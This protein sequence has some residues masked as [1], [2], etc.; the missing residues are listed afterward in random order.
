VGGVG[1]VESDGVESYGN[2]RNVHLQY[3]E[4]SQ[5]MVICRDMKLGAE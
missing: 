5:R 2:E 1:H 4:V 3:V